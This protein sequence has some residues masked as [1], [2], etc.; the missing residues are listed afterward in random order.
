MRNELTYM[1]YINNGII[2]IWGR[3]K[4]SNYFNNSTE[5]VMNIDPIWRGFYLTYEMTDRVERSELPSYLGTA[6]E[7]IVRPFVFELGNSPHALGTVDLSNMLKEPVREAHGIVWKVVVNGYDAQ[8]DFELLPPLGVGRHKFEV[9]FNRPMNKSKSPNISFGVREPYTQHSVDEDGAWNEEGTIYTAY[10]TITGKTSSDGMNRI[11]VY[12]A[13]DNE[14]FECPFEK[15]RF[16]ILIQA[17][18]SLATGFVAEPG[19]G[20]INL[21]WNNE[22][23][24]FTDAMGFNVYRYS[25]HDEQQPKLDEYGMYVWDENWNMVYETVQVA[26][27]IRL[28]TEMLDI[29]TTAYTDYDVTPGIDYHYF[30]RVLSTDLKE[31]DVSNVVSATPLTATLGDANG[32]G[33]VD[34]ADVITTVGYVTGQEPKPFIFEAADMNTDQQINIY[35]VVGIIQKIMNPN[36]DARIASDEKAVYTV[37]DG[38]LYVESPIALAGVQAQLALDGKGEKE[39]VKVSSDLTGFEHA[40]AWLSDNDYLFLA[41]SMNGKMLGAGKHALLYIGDA[42]VNSLRLSDAYGHNVTAI[43]GNTTAIN[44]MGS[45]VMNVKGI[46]TLGGQKLSGNSN[47]LKKLPKG[48]YIIN[49]EKVVK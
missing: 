32:S 47:D 10:C 44:R 42:D 28:N 38:T 41:Y 26:D 17:A 16:N 4:T 13:E 29:S 34:V 35:D 8:D 37:E 12:G 40:S 46:Y 27:T 36:A 31:F 49:G 3:L 6:K 9:Y 1:N 21:T 25:Y 24:D 48:V 2:G 18:G 11:Y 33:E 23:N 19:M 14:Y 5:D 15:S 22:N 39:D 20:R 45:D 7:E 30:Y 43:A